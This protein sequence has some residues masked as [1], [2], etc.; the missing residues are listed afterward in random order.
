MVRRMFSYAISGGARTLTGT[1]NWTS[2]A[3][4]IGTGKEFALVVDAVTGTSPSFDI[5]YTCSTESDGTYV[6]P[7][8]NLIVNDATA[9]LVT[10]F[11]PVPV[12][13]VKFTLTNNTVNSVVLTVKL[14][15]Q[16]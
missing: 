12:K 5:S 14:M 13:W 6:T 2:E 9:A 15:V 3:I 10:A 16:E 4:N 7:A 8:S 11:N 1:A